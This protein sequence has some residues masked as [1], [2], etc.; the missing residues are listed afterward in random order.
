M[1]SIALVDH[2]LETGKQETGTSLRT[3]STQFLSVEADDQAFLAEEHL[4]LFDHNDMD[5]DWLGEIQDPNL[6]WNDSNNGGAQDLTECRAPPRTGNTGLPPQSNADHSNLEASASMS[7][8]DASNIAWELTKTQL[9]DYENLKAAVY[10]YLPDYHVPSY[11]TL[12]RY[13][14][15]YVGGFDRTLP[16]IREPMM[17]LESCNPEVVLGMAAIGA[18]E[19]SEPQNSLGLFQA[20]KKIA[21]DNLRIWRARNEEQKTT[22]PSHT[23]PPA[24]GREVRISNADNESMR[25]SAMESLRAL[26]ILSF[27]GLWGDASLSKDIRGFQNLMIEVA[28]FD[29]LTEGPYQSSATGTWNACIQEETNRRTKF[30]L[31]CLL[32]LQTVISDVPSPVLCSEWR[33]RLS[34]PVEIWGAQHEQES[35]AKVA[36]SEPVLFQDIFQALLSLTDSD[37]TLKTKFTRALSQ[38]NCTI[39]ILALLQ[40]IY[41]LRQLCYATGDTLRQEE[42][43]RIQRAIQYLESHVRASQVQ[44]FADHRTQ[45]RYSDMAAYRD[46]AYARLGADVGIKRHL[47][48]RD[49]HKIAESLCL[50]PLRKCYSS[51]P[52]VLWNSIGQLE[53][54]ADLGVPYACKNYD[55]YS[56]VPQALS[57]LEAGMSLSR[58]LFSIALGHHRDP[59][60]SD[61]HQMINYLQSLMQE[62]AVSAPECGSVPPRSTDSLS[63]RCL[64]DLG[65]MILKTWA[66]VFTA[67]SKWALVAIIGESLDL[68]ANM[69]KEIEPRLEQVPLRLD[70]I[71]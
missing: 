53:A 46:L 27:Y 1:Q 65:I 30:V 2:A 71:G 49:A 39:I 34:C 21:L 4:D 45:F 67:K 70:M 41:Y 47:Q 37:T 22:L 58:W 5:L 69:M 48:S 8:L 42:I 33:L 54:L 12:R 10:R 19:R 6:H 3:P 17:C 11:H 31:F 20:S 28:Q 57:T 7:T 60:T 44:D 38:F 40:R 23:F 64:F 56:G 51:A 13:I 61:E 55:C 66:H 63:T 59:L 43:Q 15:G 18:H 26:L 9:Q 32:N 52:A 24:E 16:F 35:I 50:V 62:V 29:G 25:H 36:M 14:D 68:C